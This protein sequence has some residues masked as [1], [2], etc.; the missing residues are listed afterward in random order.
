MRYSLR[1]I[2]AAIAAL[3]CAACLLAAPPPRRLFDH[4][5]REGDTRP[6][7]DLTPPI[8]SPRGEGKREGSY[9]PAPA[10]KGPGVRSPGWQPNGIIVCDTANCTLPKIVTDGKHGAIICWTENHRGADSVNRY[11]DDIYAQ[12]V[13]SGGNFVWQNQGVPVCSLS[14]SWSNYPA[15]IPDGKGGAIIAWEDGRDGLGYTRVFAQR[16][17]SLG[18]RLWPENGVLVCNQM[19]GYVDLCTDGHGGAIVAY[20]DGRDEA[21]TSDNIYAQRIDSAGNPAWTA[22]GVPVCVSDSI[23]FWHKIVNEG[24]SNAIV[25]WQDYRGGN[26]DIYSQK[27]DSI[28]TV[29]W[30]TNGVDV[31]IPTSQD[32]RYPDL[33]FNNKG[34]AIISW[35]DNSD[36]MTRMQS[37]DSIGNKLWNSTGVNT[38]GGYGRINAVLRG[39][40][41]SKCF[42]AQRV[43]SSGIVKWGSGILLHGDSTGGHSDA[44]GDGVNGIIIIWDEL[45]NNPFNSDQYVQKVDSSGYLL[46]SSTGVPVCT[47]QVAGETYPQVESDGLG[48][49]I[50]AWHGW[51]PGSRYT[52]YRD[53]IAQRVYANGTPGGVGGAPSVHRKSD[54]YIITCPNPF[55]LRT[56]IKYQLPERAQVSLKVYNVCGQLVKT[57]ASAIQDAGFHAVEWNGCDD[58]SKSVAAGVYLYRLQAGSSL[59]TRKIVLIR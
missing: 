20:V 50:S 33:V 29:Q 10:G 24:Y 46:W 14:G 5:R 21:N 45:R 37:I 30:L 52:P 4:E 22:D 8:P 7:P 18:N 51:R 28:G 11:S 2:T 32:E 57:L 48:G 6:K 56:Q 34:G 47:L 23:Q 55:K 36:Y 25:T 13:D 1:R 41:V 40:V 17:D 27:I 9:T 26:Y 53:I 39:G 54:R 59:D 12:R 43:D 42:A 44:T 58:D 38:L 35:G 15:M 19:S 3:I 49:A 31:H 16:L